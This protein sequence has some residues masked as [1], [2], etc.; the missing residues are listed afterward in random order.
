MSK[1]R[2]I[3]QVA[4]ER[5]GERFTSLW[6]HVCNLN[7]L[8]EVYFELNRESAP[9]VDRVTWRQYGENLWANL[10]D[11]CGRLMHGAYRPLPVERTYVPKGDG[12]RRPIGK[13]TVIS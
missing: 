7:R 5:P 6:H 10:T 13:P 11:L 2:R 4:K 12:S 9:G 8:H 1:L 3:R